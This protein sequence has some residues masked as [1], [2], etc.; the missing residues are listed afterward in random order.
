LGKPISPN[1]LE[2]ARGLVNLIA[3]LPGWTKKTSTISNEAQELKRMVLKANDPYKVLFTDLP[4]ILR[5]NDETELV[6][7]I[8]Q[9][10]SELQKAYP[11][12]INKFKN[13]LLSSL[14]HTG[15]ISEINQR[16][17]LIKASSGD[18][19]MDAFIARL[20]VFKN[21]NES[22][23]GLLSVVI[24]KNPK[25][26]VDRD[27]DAATLGL[28]EMC[29]K[30]RKIESLSSLI[31]KK[32]GRKAFAFV[33]TDPSESFTSENFDISSERIP[34]IN[35]YSKEILQIMRAEKLTKDEALAVFAQACN[36]LIKS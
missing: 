28:S 33:Y 23:E 35:K 32:S 3:N 24:N 12:L 26:W 4:N 34:T 6:E 5:I 11:N 31:G 9:L 30:F 36:E 14:D 21:D 2:S 15:S 22:L 1:P 27:I 17:N 19:Q 16:A 29:T 25:D 13:I 18:F 10:T 7:K 20:S 8:T